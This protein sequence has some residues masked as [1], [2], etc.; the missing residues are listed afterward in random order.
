MIPV[1]VRRVRY[2]RRAILARVSPPPHVRFS[3]GV[4][5]PVRF[6][7]NFTACA[8][9]AFTPVVSGGVFSVRCAGA[10]IDGPDPA[11]PE[12]CEFHHRGWIASS[13]LATA[14][15]IFST[16]VRQFRSTRP[17]PSSPR[18][19]IPGHA[20]IAVIYTSGNSGARARC[21]QLHIRQFQGTRSLSSVIYVRQSRGTRLLPLIPRPAIPGR[22]PIAVSFHIRQFQGKRPLPII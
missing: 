7:E 11:N 18:P 22:L 1:G 14:D 13:W 5:A 20:P 6:A 19:A 15:P 3:I 8:V 16:H 17:L 12:S 4:S 2:P 9:S 10:T 21:R